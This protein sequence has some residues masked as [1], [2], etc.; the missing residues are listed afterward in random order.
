MADIAENNPSFTSIESILIF[1]TVVFQLQ[2][3][4][5]LAKASLATHTSGYSINAQN[6]I[7]YDQVKCGL[8]GLVLE[9]QV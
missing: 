5:L 7:P 9:F 8:K 6:F 2:G 3:T 1:G 4:E